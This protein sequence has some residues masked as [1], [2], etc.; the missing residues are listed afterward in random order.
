MWPPAE[1]VFSVVD[2]AAEDVAE[3][4]LV[5]AAEVAELLSEAVAVADLVTVV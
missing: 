3:V 5:E 4:V 2:S 1:A